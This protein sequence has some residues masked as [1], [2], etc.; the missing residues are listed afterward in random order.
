MFSG[1]SL[2]TSAEW[3]LLVT[4]RLRSWRCGKVKTFYE[5]SIPGLSF[6]WA[7]VSRQW[8]K[9]E[10]ERLE[11][12]K[13]EGHD[14]IHHSFQETFGYL[15]LL[16]ERRALCFVQNIKKATGELFD[17]ALVGQTPRNSI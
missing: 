17:N 1:F 2:H 16:F 3:F 14:T 8:V 6:L 5:Y 7:V 4:E 10:Y 15:M 11:G 13:A 12:P 9:T